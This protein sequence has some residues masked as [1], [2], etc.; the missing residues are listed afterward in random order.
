MPIL[1]PE[2]RREYQR[3]W[4]NAR[5]EAGLCYDCGQPPTFGR[6]KCADCAE[7]VRAAGAGRRQR[8]KVQRKCIICGEQQDKFLCIDHIDNDGAQQRR[9]VGSGSKFMAWIV[10]NGF[11]DDLQVLCWNCNAGKQLNSGVCPHEEAVL[12]YPLNALEPVGPR[13]LHGKYLPV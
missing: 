4:R 12:E 3:H 8:R 13:V 7:K 1:D 10:K 9:E 2:K 6:T 5:A 11:P